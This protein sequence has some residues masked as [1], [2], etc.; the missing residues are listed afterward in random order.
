MSTNNGDS[1]PGSK[2]MQL[3]DALRGIALPGSQQDIV[4]EGRI[5]DLS[6]KDG[7][8]RFNLELPAPDENAED[9]LEGS[10]SEQLQRLEWISEVEL[11]FIS[12][13]N[14]GPVTALTG[15]LATAPH[16]P[17]PVGSGSVTAHADPH[18]PLDKLMPG[19]RNVIAVG[20]GKGGVGKSTVSVNLALALAAEGYRVGL[21]DGDVYGP[22]IPLMLGLTEQPLINEKE[23]LIPP[24]VHGV[25]TI[26]MGLLLRPDQAVVWRGPMVHGVMRQFIGDVEWG[27]I[28]FL[29]VDLPPG[30][31]DAP[32]SLSQAVPLTAAVVVTTPQEVAAQVAG[33]A[34]AMFEK[35]GIRILG[36]IENMSYFVCPHC[37]AQTEIFD[38]GGGKQLAEGTKSPFLGEIPLDVRM[39]KGGDIGQPVMVQFPDSDLAQQFRQV[40]RKLAAEVVAYKSEAAPVSSNA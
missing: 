35:L 36:V 22:S 3:L 7:E 24:E 25:K 40:A 20:S 2:T 21:L 8:V 30:T 27:E 33:K 26:S 34:I 11:G 31:G 28:D 6:I 29:I 10:I 13:S 23:K 5:K 39:R 17:L 15:E 19:V 1:R 38:R 32:L 14:S 16:T 18:A 37:E 12:S 9:F 4:A